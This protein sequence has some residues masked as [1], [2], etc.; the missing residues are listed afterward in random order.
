MFPLPLV[1]TVKP[2]R[3]LSLA[4]GVLHLVASVALLLA[5]LPV[6]AQIAGMVI[7]AASLLAHS[8]PGPATHLR[9]NLDGRLEIRL[10]G[11]CRQTERVSI[12]LAK[13]HII[14]IHC[15]IGEDTHDQFL[16][17]LSDST[18]VENKR[19]LRVWLMWLAKTQG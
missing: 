7:L 16:C 5:N 18:S 4:V 8:R 9:C 1:L 19:R 11:A 10:N 3:Q 17:V 6:P 13:P 15:R 12:D 2:S 14:I